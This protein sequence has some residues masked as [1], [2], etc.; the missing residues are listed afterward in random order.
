MELDWEAAKVEYICD[1][2]ATY[3]SIAEK[4]GCSQTQVANRS[5]DEGWRALREEYL[6]KSLK[7]S[8]DAVAD[9]RKEHALK[10]DSAAAALLDK[11]VEAIDACTSGDLLGDGRLARALTGALIDL[12]KI[13][14][15]KSD[16][17]MREQ[18]ARI[19]N[20]QR[21]AVR[22]DAGANEITVVIG[23]EAGEWAE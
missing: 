17:D 1:C 23:E 6:Q 19:A 3:R 5:K 14:N 22:D 8:L 21:Q 12:Q 4:Y 11:L 9:R 20:L 2:K 15:I 7:N 16:A 18:E 13:H 10:I